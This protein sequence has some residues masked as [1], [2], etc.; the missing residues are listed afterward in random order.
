MEKFE[1]FEKTP[2]AAASIGQVHLAVLKN[3]D[4]K[5]AIKLQVITIIY[6]H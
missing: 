1:I 6:V 3:T 5:V 2:F 4:E